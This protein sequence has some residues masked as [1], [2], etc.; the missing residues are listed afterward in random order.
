MLPDALKLLEDVRIAAER[1]LGLAANR[2]REELER[3]W[4]LR[5]AVERQFEIIGEA[6]ARLAKRD[7][8]T[9]EKLTDYRLIISFRNR[10]IHTYDN[11]DHEVVWQA[12]RVSLPQLY[13]QVMTL[14][15]E[16]A[17]P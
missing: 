10:L 5:S 7:P 1:I 12:I 15:G 4:A 11:I 3:D 13:Q 2:E 8:S 14:L 9:A 17:G 16:A 6:V